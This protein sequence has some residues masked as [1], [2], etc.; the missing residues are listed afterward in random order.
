MII[1]EVGEEIEEGTKG[2]RKKGGLFTLRRSYTKNV[3]AILRSSQAAPPRIRRLLLECQ[4][5]W[6]RGA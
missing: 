2:R 6:T 1:N 4:N 5:E 3:V